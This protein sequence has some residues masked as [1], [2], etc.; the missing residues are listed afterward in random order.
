MKF[1]N[2][3]QRAISLII[4]SLS[5][6]SCKKE[7]TTLQDGTFTGV[8]SGRNGPVEVSI[9]VQDG[10]IISAEITKDN[11][12]PEIA[13]SAKESIINQF[14]KAKSTSMIDTVS[15]ATITSNAILDA[16]D[17]AMATSQGV[18]KAAVVYHDTE[19]DIAIIGAGGAGL[20]AATEA[21]SRGMR[22]IVLEKMGIVGGNSNYSTGGINA[23]YT[24]EQERL[25]IKDSKEVFFNDTMKGGQYLN[26]PELVHTLVDNSADIVEWLQSPI[27]GA[28]L[29]DVGMF[30]G[31]TNKRIHR[32]KGGGAIGAHLV[33]LLHKAAQTQ[34]AEIRLNNKVIDIIQENGIATGVKV[35][36]NSG[37]YK[38]KAK[39][40]IIATGGFG[41]NPD[42]I[43]FYQASLK[44]FGTTNHKGATGDAFKMVEKFDAALTQMEQ[45][46]THP[47][48][49]KGTGIMITEAV[50]GNGAILVNKN[51]RRFINEMETRDIVSAAVLR[52]P[53][54]V[55]YI[56]FDQGVR[57]SLKAIEGYA[58]QN[59][60]TEGASIK[61]LAEKLSIDAVALKYTVDEY[62]KAVLAKNDP[63]FER[64]PASM[65]HTLSKAPF[66]AIEVEPAVHHTMGGLKINPKAQVL[67][68]S[69]QA[70]PG[71]FAAGEVTGGVHGAERLGG[72][73]VADICIFGK[74]AADSA[75]EYSKTIH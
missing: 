17:E 65:E 6:F 42:M 23:A 54:K 30:G 70:I 3:A 55:A 26:D 58:K 12:T 14:I 16:L 10:S 73:A 8:G 41:A 74:I 56:V 13:S 68:K 36:A 75:T 21:A 69:G 19:C 60:L 11:E 53:G 1:L 28:D 72:N 34:G 40:V 67:N 25:G 15:G 64:N 20:T 33:P 44:D 7:N 27:V 5:L 57:E 66:Y 52:G 35:L 45:I 37:E 22:V 51:G 43:T 9:T 71:L 50:R 4:I 47:T 63:E 49:V 62:N 38:I 32:P 29:S 48:V 61:E 46:Q 18:K 2:A 31:A 39:A 24:K 59:L